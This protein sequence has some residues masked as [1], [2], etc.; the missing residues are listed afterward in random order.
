MITDPIEFPN[1]GQKPLGLYPIV[2]SVEWLERLL[3]LGVDTIQLRIKDK[4]DAI[5][6]NEIKRSIACA[7]KFNARLFINDYWELAIAYG[8]Y[9]VHLGQEDLKIANIEAIRQAGLRLGISTHN[10]EEII[11][12]QAVYPS[13]IAYGPIYPT[14]SKSMVAQCVGIQ[15]LRKAVCMSDRP[16][17]AIG[18]INLQR[19]ASTLKTGV[20]GV[21]V[22][23]A[24]TRASC[25]E[26]MTR[27]LLNFFIT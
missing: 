25:P 13:Y 1:N 4:Q 6:E 20:D 15:K 11:C 24:I 23:A 5:L 12:A 26:T 17:V 9:G 10:D 2:D 16:V 19:I 3:P 21:A 18:G 14:A 7:K 22:I 27:K 8:A